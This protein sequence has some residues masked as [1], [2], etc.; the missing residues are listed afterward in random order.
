MQKA[1]VFNKEA[2]RYFTTGVEKL[3]CKRGY[4]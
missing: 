1:S 3:Y 2:E 4:R